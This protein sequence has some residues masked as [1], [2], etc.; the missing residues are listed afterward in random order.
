VFA[1][2]EAADGPNLSVKCK[3]G[4]AESLCE[5]FDMSPQVVKMVGE[6]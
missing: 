4:G 1:Y 2:D 3:L 5:S 6:V